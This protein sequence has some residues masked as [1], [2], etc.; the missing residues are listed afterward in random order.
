MTFAELVQYLADN[1]RFPVLDECVLKTIDKARAGSHRDPVM[2]EIVRAMFEG[3]GLEGPHSPV[4]RAQ[5]TL[6]LGPLRLRYM[7][8]DAPIEGFRMVDGV[9]RAIDG[10]FDE[11]ALRARF[12]PARTQPN[13]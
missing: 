6:A 8:D 11:E 9:V 7:K 5:A 10:A 2:G 3:A 13:N 4:T 12:A 1:T